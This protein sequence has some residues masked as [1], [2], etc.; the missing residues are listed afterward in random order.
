M[1]DFLGFIQSEWTAI[2]SAP[3]TFILLLITSFGAAFYIANWRYEGIVESLKE[4]IELF[5]ERLEAKDG[6]LGEYRERLHLLPTTE[7]TYSRFTN[8]EL[9][10]KT[11][12]VVG[13]IRELLNSRNEKQHDLIFPIEP[14]N[15]QNMSEEESHKLWQR[16]TNALV[17]EIAETIAIYVRDFKVDTILLRDEL[18]SRLPNS[19]KNERQYRTYEYPTNPIGIGIVADD[20]ER[21]SKSLPS[22]GGS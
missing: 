4:R 14:K 2:S 16:K 19:A 17:K 18:L 20:L 8:A 13:R 15:Y 10:Q 1:K 5:K 12:D 3:I 6:Q 9:K 11:L 21:L 7:T 22:K